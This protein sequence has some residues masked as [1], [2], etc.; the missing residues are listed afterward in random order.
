M[1]H[2]KKRHQLNRFS[3]W[4]K[5]TLNSM[6]RSI[7]LYQSVKTTKTKAKAVKPL[8]DKLI[9]LGKDNT[10]AAKREAFRILQDHKLVSRLFTEIAPRFAN[11]AGGY[12][13]MLNYGIRRGDN[14]SLT[15]LELTEIKKKEQ[16]KKTVKEVKEQPEK[17]SK[18]GQ[19]PQAQEHKH[20]AGPV[21]KESK[22]EL[23][24]KPGKKF[25]GGLKQIFKKQRETF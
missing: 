25:L 19:E 18:T 16:K 15:I 12:T 22:P 3:S 13:R 4:R 23:K 24:K 11:R 8:I 21:I 7:L 5:A 1:R 9:T 6:A 2:A 10:L 17:S 20:E 14:A